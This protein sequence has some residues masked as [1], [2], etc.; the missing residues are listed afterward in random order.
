MNTRLPLADYLALDYPFQAIADP[1]GG[2]V[3]LFPDLPGCM[4]QVETIDEIGPA[5]AEIKE[6]WLETEHERGAEIPLPSYPEPYSGKFNLR[7]P[8]TLHR[9]LVEQAEAEG[10]SLNQLVVSMLSE[11]APLSEVLAAVRALGAEQAELRRDVSSVAAQADELRS[12]AA[13]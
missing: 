13:A 7:L 11:R 10:V 8:K 4:T 5:A 9:R 3:I 6:L 12:Q 1:D 2:Y